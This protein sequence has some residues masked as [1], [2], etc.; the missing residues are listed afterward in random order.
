MTIT[1][2]G[3][4]HDDTSR[5]DAADDGLE[6][7]TVGIAAL[8]LAGSRR[9]LAERLDHRGEGRQL[10]DRCV[11]EGLVGLLAAAAEAGF[12]RLVGGDEADLA[13]RVAEADRRTRVVQQEALAFCAALDDDGI[14]HRVLDGPAVVPRVYHDPGRRPYT[15]VDVVVHPSALDQAR[16]RAGRTV[17][18]R[19]E[20]LPPNAGARLRLADLDGAVVPVAVAGGAL[21]GL[22]LDVV[23]VRA[24]AVALAGGPGRLMALRDVAQI[25]LAAGA[26]GAA[27][28]ERA[29]GWRCDRL[30]AAGL[31][32]A[33]DTFDLADKT[34]LSV[35]AAR[36][37]EPTVPARALR[38]ATGAFGPFDRL[39]GQLHRLG[40]ALG[41]RER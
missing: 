25:A 5:A 31:R 2:R 41:R 12:V 4:G 8:G 39:A 10:I 9:F 16:A 36:H 26:R 35:W 11:T 37:G 18:V 15:G 17:R 38:A 6:R 33:W 14:D 29:V 30:V 27:V 34:D 3:D 13:A 24:T 28:R 1:G 23:L 19:T 21:P 40:H 32:Q 7:V 20:I 22:P